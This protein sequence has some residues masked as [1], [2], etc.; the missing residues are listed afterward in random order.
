M[1]D[2]MQEYFILERPDNDRLPLLVPDANTEAMKYWDE[3]FKYKGTPLF[4]NDQYK[5]SRGDDYLPPVVHYL[6]FLHDDI[7]IDGKA[8][9]IMVDELAIQGVNFVPSVFIN[10]EW[11]EDYWYL[12]GIDEI[13]CWCRNK[14]DYNPKPRRS[15]GWHY[16]YKY[17]LNSSILEKIPL[18]KRMVFKM[19]GVSMPIICVHSSIVETM[20]SKLNVIDDF[21]IP[22]ADY[23][24]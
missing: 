13:D 6:L 5:Q 20:K 7:I 10:E 19:G 16:V 1:I 3:K 15:T 11:L 18:E 17:V 12:Q 8:K 9:Q 2:F 22:L 14:S 24:S 23:E 21:F 4:F